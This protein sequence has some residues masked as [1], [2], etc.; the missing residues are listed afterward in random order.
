MFQA[1]QGIAKMY[2][3]AIQGRMKSLRFLALGVA[4]G[5]LLAHSIVPHEHT[6]SPFEAHASS[7][8]GFDLGQDHL[9]HYTVSQEEVSEARNAVVVYGFMGNS[10][11]HWTMAY[12]KNPRAHS[13]AIKTFVASGLGYSWAHRPP[14]SLA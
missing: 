4:V 6:D 3:Q 13:P 9:E 10:I 11:V 12:S 8:V 14:P 1:A 5:L 2:R 7:P